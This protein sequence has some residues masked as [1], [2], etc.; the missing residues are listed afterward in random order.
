MKKH[1]GLFLAGQ[2]SGVEGYVES[3]AMGLLA[4][5]N[6]VQLA[7]D[8]LITVPPPA[9]AFGA[10]VHHLTESEPAH[11]QPSNINFGLFPPLQKKI[12]KRDRGKFRSDQ[13]LTLL[14]EWKI[15]V[16]QDFAI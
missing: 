9:T 8:K 12:K 14:E 13:A 7:T 1:P 4:G 10:L 6:A 3:A 2:L 11:F 5:I 15:K 16:N